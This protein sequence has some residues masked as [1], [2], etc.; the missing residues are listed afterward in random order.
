MPERDLAAMR[1][2]ASQNA[3]IDA[4]RDSNLGDH[5]LLGIH[6]GVGLMVPGLTTNPDG[7]G[8]R[9]RV[10]EGVDT[11]CSSAEN[12]LNIEAWKY[13]K[14]YNQKMMLLWQPNTK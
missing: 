4:I 6:N 13:A 3:D 14:I 12:N 9:L 8:Y 11:P 1:A 10:I 2:L 5:R 7:S